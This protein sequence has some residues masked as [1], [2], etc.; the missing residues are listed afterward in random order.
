MPV[1]RA[2]DP[3]GPGR[4]GLAVVRG[5]SMRPTLADG[6]RLL[7]DYRGEARPGRVAV[8]R[9]PGGVVAVKRLGHREPDGSWWVERDNPAEGVDSWSVGAV[10][11][12]DVVAVVVARVWPSPRRL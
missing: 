7:A 8:V 2:K 9:L 3:S 10:P 1:R 11:R 6:D 5:R 4:W 12:A